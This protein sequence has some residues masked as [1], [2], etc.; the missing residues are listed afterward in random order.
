MTFCYLILI[1]SKY[2]VRPRGF[3]P[4]AYGFV[5]RCSIQLSYGRK[6]NRCIHAKLHLC[7]DLRFVSARLLRNAAHKRD[8][9]LF[10]GERVDTKMHGIEPAFPL[11]FARLS[12]RHLH[13]GIVRLIG[14]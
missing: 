5:V 3:E 1:A 13:C 14:K 7:T 2:M 10:M 6:I 12:Y 4:L 9:E 8:C 11:L